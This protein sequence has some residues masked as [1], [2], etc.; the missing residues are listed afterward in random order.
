MMRL[1]KRLTQM[2]FG[3]GGLGFVLG[4]VGCSS[5]E[6]CQQVEAEPTVSLDAIATADDTFVSHSYSL[7][8]ADSIGLAAFGQQ[9][10]LDDQR[11]NDERLAEAN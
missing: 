10:V 7:V 6:T 1:T 5:F 9:I 11:I 8:A 3:F 2:V 4:T